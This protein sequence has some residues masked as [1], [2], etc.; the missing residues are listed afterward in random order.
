MAESIATG[1]VHPGLYEWPVW[2]EKAVVAVGLTLLTCR[3]S[4]RLCRFLAGGLDA[5]VFNADESARP[6]E[7]E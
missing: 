6:D 1:E 7:G 4:V 2:A 5:S 3:I